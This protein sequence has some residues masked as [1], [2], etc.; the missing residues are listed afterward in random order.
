MFGGA[1][2]LPAHDVELQTRP[3]HVLVASGEYEDSVPSEACSFLTK[4]RY[5][6]LRF[7]MVR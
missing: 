3:N 6:K 1:R 7:S 2:S 4:V 5:L